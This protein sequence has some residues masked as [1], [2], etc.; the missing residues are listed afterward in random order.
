MLPFTR[1]EGNQGSLVL[2]FPPSDTKLY[3]LEKMINSILPFGFGVDK[4]FSGVF[5]F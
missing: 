1:Q 5:L 3:K 4:V 2:D